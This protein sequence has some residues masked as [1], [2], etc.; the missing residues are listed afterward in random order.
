MMQHSRCDSKYVEKEKLM[1]SFIKTDNGNFIAT[2]EVVQLEKIHNT[3][4]LVTT[5]QGEKHMVLKCVDK[6]RKKIELET[7][8]CIKA[9]PGYSVVFLRKDL[10]ITKSAVIAWARI[11][12]RKTYDEFHSR[13]I[14]AGR[15][16]KYK[17]HALVEPN[18]NVRDEAGRIFPNIESWVEVCKRSL[19]T[20][21]ELF[22]PDDD[23]SEDVSEENDV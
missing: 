5:K 12:S 13:P 21:Q 8:A 6:L 19:L 18:G 3:K 10:S 17:L 9:D 16:G 4:T 15:A 20:L 1:T 22:A 2:S 11:D 14:T 7:A 23:A